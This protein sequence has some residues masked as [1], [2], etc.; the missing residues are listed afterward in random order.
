MRK[1][2]TDCV[3][4]LNSAA[5][6]CGFGHVGFPAIIRSIRLEAEENCDFLPH[7]PGPE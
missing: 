7:D 2:S 1:I 5:M 4:F 3:N 6:R